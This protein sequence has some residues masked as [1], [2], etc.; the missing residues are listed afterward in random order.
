MAKT[1]T[2][3]DILQAEHDIISESDWIGTDKNDAFGDLQ[4]WMGVHD[5][6]ESLIRMIKKDAK[7][8]E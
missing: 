6:A 3:L 5:M 4:Y 8:G 1:L 7:K 2:E